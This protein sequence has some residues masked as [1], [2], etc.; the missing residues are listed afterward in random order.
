ML[1]EV[2]PFFTW[3]PYDTYLILQDSTDMFV[4]NVADP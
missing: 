4:S 3:D 2:T 1:I